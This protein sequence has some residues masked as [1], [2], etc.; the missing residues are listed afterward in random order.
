MDVLDAIRN[1][2]TIRRFQDRPVDRET[3]AVLLD[4]AVRAPNH[5]LTEPWRFYVLDRAALDRFAEELAAPLR[6]RG[7]DAETLRKFKADLAPAPLAVAVTCKTSASDRRARED[8]AATCAAIENMLLAAVGLGLGGY[9]RT[10]R[11][12]SDPAVRAC[13]GIPPE[14]EVVGFVYFGFP[15]EAGGSARTPWTDKTVWV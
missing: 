2:R 10:G 4:A 12:V 15:A 11:L 3:V 5:R 14:E 8:Y 7:A 13:L 6:A 9:W 1:R